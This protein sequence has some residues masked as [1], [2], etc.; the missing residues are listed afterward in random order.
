MNQTILL[1][2][3]KIPKIMGSLIHKNELLKFFA[4]GTLILCILSITVL[5]AVVSKPPI[6]IPLASTGEIFTGG[7]MPAPESEIE[8]A[9][10]EYLDLRYIWEP[11]TVETNLKRAESF[12]ASQ[13]LKAYQTQI[14]NVV[15]FSKEKMVS[16]KIFVGNVNVDLA[17]HKIQITGDRITSIQGFKASGDLTLE[18]DYVC[19]DRS[20]EN[21]WGIFIT[22]EKEANQ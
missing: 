11:K 10:N 3:T 12:I 4:I 9:I 21:P 5:R 19:G 8:R 18:L 6:V 16:Q 22:K 15:R 1:K 2:T 7:P 13:S 20:K 14:A 17:T